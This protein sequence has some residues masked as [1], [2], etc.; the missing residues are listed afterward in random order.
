MASRLKILARYS[1][2][3]KGVGVLIMH[4]KELSIKSCIREIFSPII[5]HM[6]QCTK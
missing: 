3:A 1:S 5:H 6:K 4:Q 2:V